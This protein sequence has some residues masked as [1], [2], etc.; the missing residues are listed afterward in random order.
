MHKELH[1]CYK[2]RLAHSNVIWSVTEQNSH[3]IS[4][5]KWQCVANEPEMHTLKL[6]Y[7]FLACIACITQMHPPARDGVVWSVCLSAGYN[8]VPCKNSRANWMSFGVWNHV[9]PRNHV[10]VL[11]GGLHCPHRKGTFGGH[12]WIYLITYHQKACR[13][14]C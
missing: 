8:C 4:Q 13:N 14:I 5:S 11:D 2:Q 9:G 7:Y 1:C 3:S 10:I 6:I 12:I